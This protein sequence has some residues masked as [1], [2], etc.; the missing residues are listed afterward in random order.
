MLA[1]GARPRILVPT[2]VDARRL[3]RRLGKTDWERSVAILV[4]PPTPL[5][6]I[7]RFVSPNRILE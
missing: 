7:R 6:C 2:Q 4:V 3:E 1:A 5:A